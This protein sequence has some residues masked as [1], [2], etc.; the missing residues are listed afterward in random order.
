MKFAR[1]LIDMPDNNLKKGDIVVYDSFVHWWR[2]V[3][4]ATPRDKTEYVGKI[5]ILKKMTD[6]FKGYNYLP[7]S[8]VEFL[9]EWELKKLK[10][11]LTK[12]LLI[13]YK[14]SMNESLDF[15]RL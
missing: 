7:E 11:H 9:S 10:P 4:V 1:M 2:T 15:K 6:R 13:D 3:K 14:I 12:T 5:H 8:S